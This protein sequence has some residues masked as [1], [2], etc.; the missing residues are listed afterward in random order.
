MTRTKRAFNMKQKAFFTI[1]KGLSIARNCLKP[2]SGSL[3]RIVTI[4]NT[5]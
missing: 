5:V 4:K 2:K 3:L 1:F